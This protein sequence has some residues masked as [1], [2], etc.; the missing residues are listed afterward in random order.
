MNSGIKTNLDIND[1]IYWSL[2]NLVQGPCPRNGTKDKGGF[3]VKNM[4]SSNSNG[5]FASFDKAL[6]HVTRLCDT[7]AYM[8]YACDFLYIFKVH[9]S[10]DLLEI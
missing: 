2:L 10:K 5:F 6:M 9:Q 1:R 7:Y 3:L 8:T 4:A